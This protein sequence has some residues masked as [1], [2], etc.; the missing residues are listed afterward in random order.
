ML[1]VK[2]GEEDMPKRCG[3]IWEKRMLLIAAISIVVIGIGVGWKLNQ[4]INQLHQMVAQIESQQRGPGVTSGWAGLTWCSY[5][6]SITFESSW[7]DYVTEYFGFFEHYQRGLGGC[8]FVNNGQTWYANAD[9]TYNSM[10]GFAGVWEAPEGT[11]EHEG[12]M[13]SWDRIT[14][15]IPQDVDLVVIMAGTNDADQATGSPMGDLSY[16]FDEATFKGAVASTVIKIQEWVPDAVIV[17]ASPPSGRGKFEEWMEKDSDMNRNQTEAVYNSL[18][19]TTQDYAEAVEEVA[20][21]LS[22]PFI[23]V[24]GNTGINPFNRQK[25]IRDLVHPTPEGGKA[26]ARIM[27]GGLER[28]APIDK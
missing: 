3:N 28:L 25:Y 19:F 9:G 17:L 10:R 1:L 18:G 2:Q 8:R 27:I 24:F 4:K 13:C 20:E 12:W 26:I 15:M 7:Q 14:T 11:T 6:D 21:Y 5:G 23:D 22:I 16:P